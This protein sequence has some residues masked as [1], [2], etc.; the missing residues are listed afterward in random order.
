MHTNHII[1]FL[2]LNSRK[3]PIFWKLIAVLRNEENLLYIEI[4]NLKKGNIISKK[5]RGWRSFESISSQYYKVY[6][7][8]I[9]NINDSNDLRKKDKKTNLWYEACLEFLLYDYNL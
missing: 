2:I 6:D 8:E 5:K 1:M 3:K 7:E 4:D 9:K